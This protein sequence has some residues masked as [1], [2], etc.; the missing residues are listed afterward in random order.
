MSETENTQSSFGWILKNLL[1]AAAFF[2]IIALLAHILLGVFTHHGRV[3]EVPDMTNM[4]V[5]EAEAAAAS[6]GIRVDVI[7]STYQRGMA[8]GAVYRQ[9]PAGGQF[10]KS[11]RRILLTIN[12][13]VPKKESVPNLVGLSMRQAQAEL[14]SRGLNVGKLIYVDDIAT[15]NVLKQTYRGRDIAPG[16]KV[17]SGSSIDL[18]VGLSADDNSTFIPN[19]IGQKYV[20]AI[21]VIHESSLNVGKLTFDGSVRNFNDSISAVVYRQNPTGS[22]EFPTL[23]GSDVSLYLTVDPEKMK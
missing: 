21:K 12:T 20:N 7:D 15:N 11:G 22:N 10:V 16:S 17:N 3:I 6:A 14:F 9:N 4:S 18:V 5:A 1:G 8:A 13:V 19:V 2:I 23:K